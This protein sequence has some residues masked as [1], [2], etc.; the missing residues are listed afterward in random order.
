MELEG[1]RFVRTYV[2]FVL[3]KEHYDRFL[4][5]FRGLKL[6]LIGKQIFYWLTTRIFQT[7][8][9]VKVTPPVSRKLL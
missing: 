3:H 4:V 5:D 7:T 6:N 1:F 9:P 8:K 2:Y